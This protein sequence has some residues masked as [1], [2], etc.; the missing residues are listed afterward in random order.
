M[1]WIFI[2]NQPHLHYID[3]N[4]VTTK[5]QLGE[6]NSVFERRNMITTCFVIYKNKLLLYSV[7]NH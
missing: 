2:N 1:M 6:L 3:N 7:W 5:C 4:Q